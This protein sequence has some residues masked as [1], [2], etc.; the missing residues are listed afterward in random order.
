MRLLYLALVPLLLAAGAA[1]AQ[2]STLGNPATTVQ[3]IDV[4]GRILPARC[5]V[6]AGRLD[7]SEY[8]CLCPAGGDRI[9]VP[10]CARDERP[11][12]ESRAFERL[13]KQVSRDG[14]LAGDTFDGRRIC[15]RPRNTY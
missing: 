14:S 10:V 15:A 11:P 7:K 6:P 13:R 4:S 9:E 1:T 8:I 12:P 3:C 2:S 5:N